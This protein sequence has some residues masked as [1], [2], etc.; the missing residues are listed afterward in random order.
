MKLK[1]NVS[2]CMIMI[3][4]SC[5]SSTT[6]STDVKD[7]T[8]NAETTS[9]Q[10]DTSHPKQLVHIS[11]KSTFKIL[12]VSK[13]YDTTNDFDKQS[14][15]VCKK[16][17]LDSSKILKIIQNS[18]PITGEDIH[19]GYEELPCY[20]KGRLR[21]DTSEF[22]YKVNAGGFVSIFSPDT[23]IYRGYKKHD[24]RKLFISSPVFKKFE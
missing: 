3:L 21:I 5:N 14:E 1:H 10:P 2:Y 24:A 17:Q 4:L 18:S 16:W 9:N 22:S 20:Y 13:Y 19:Y 23:G 15:Q 7:T 12:T 8:R 11:N 6:N